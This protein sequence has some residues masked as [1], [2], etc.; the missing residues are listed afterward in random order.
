MD[1][2]ETLDCPCCGQEMKIRIF[3]ERPKGRFAA[4][5]KFE[6]KKKDHCIQVYLLTEPREGK[7]DKK[8][9]EVVSVSSRAEKLLE[10]ANRLSGEGVAA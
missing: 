8:K 3:A 4:G 7:P 1:P 9:G 10:R 6:C 2:L 5:G